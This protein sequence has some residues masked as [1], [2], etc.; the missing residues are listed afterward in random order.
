MNQEESEKIHELCSRIAVENDHQEFLA[1]VGELNRI[2]SR[3][4]RSLHFG[5][6]S[7]SK[8]R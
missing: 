2:L 4:D 7:E 1:L 8:K 3:H 5:S 6:S